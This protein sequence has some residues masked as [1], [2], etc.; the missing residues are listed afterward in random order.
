MDTSVIAIIVPCYNEEE[1]L[2]D[3]HKALSGILDSMISTGMA[4]NQSYLLFVD[5]GSRDSTWD[6][7]ESLAAAD[8]HTRG[9]KLAKNAGHQNALWAGLEAASEDCDASISIDADLQDDINAIPEMVKDFHNGSDVVYGVRDDRTSDTIF[10]RV[11]AQSYYRL[12]RRLGADLVYN[13]A[14]FRLMSR[15]AMI[16]LLSFDERA[17]FLRGLVTCVGYRHSSVFYARKP[18]MAGESKYPLRKMINF[19]VNGI[20]SFS[21]KPVRLIFS[22]GLIFLIIA[23]G[24]LIYA[25]VSYFRGTVTPGWTSIILSI[26]FASGII[27][28]ALGV[29]GEYVGNIF[30]E[31]KHRPRF[32][33]EKRRGGKYQDNR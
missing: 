3:T 4:D 13:H 20:T 15:R 23:F 17:I 11:T 14:D 6:I 18:R 2:H 25:L 1:V 31:V 33:I 16:D 19:A 30:M 9:I 22:I 12:M 32:F 27:L 5:D 28:L 7:I 26:W 8:P 10:K 21:V 29:I 24:I